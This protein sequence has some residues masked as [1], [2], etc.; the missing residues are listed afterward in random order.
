[1]KKAE[2]FTEKSN[3]VENKKT[4]LTTK[5]KACLAVTVFV[6]MLLFAVVVGTDIGEDI[7]TFIYNIFH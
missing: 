6:A 3:D 4:G 1:M 5:G 2:C 7:G